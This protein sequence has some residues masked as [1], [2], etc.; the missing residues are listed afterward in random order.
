[1]FL[2]TEPE[3]EGEGDVLEVL[4]VDLDLRQLRVDDVVSNEGHMD[5]AGNR[6]R[7]AQERSNFADYFHPYLCST[8]GLR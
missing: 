4:A 8:A 5:D 2:S 3:D 7:G 1:M 6:E